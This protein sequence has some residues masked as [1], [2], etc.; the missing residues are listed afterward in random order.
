MWVKF[1]VIFKKPWDNAELLAQVYEGLEF[2]RLVEANT[3][4]KKNYLAE[5]ATKT[6][7]Q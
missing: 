4:M 2:Y 6:I 1:I 3:L 5:Q 7:K